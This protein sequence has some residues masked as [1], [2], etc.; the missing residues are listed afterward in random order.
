MA[1][2]YIYISFTSMNGKNGAPS[3]GHMD[4]IRFAMLH[5][6]GTT[7]CAVAVVRPLSL[8]GETSQT[9]HDPICNPRTNSH[10]GV[11]P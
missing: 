9:L 7:A 3:F 2:I 5:C 11:Y 4:H 8:T 1:Y 10:R 6:H